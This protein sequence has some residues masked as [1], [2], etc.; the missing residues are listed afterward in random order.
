MLYFRPHCQGVDLANHD[1]VG[2]SSLHRADDRLPLFLDL[3]TPE[4][5]NLPGQLVTWSD[6]PVY[7]PESQAWHKAAGGHYWF[8]WS[9]RPTPESL[10]RERPALGVAWLLGDGQKWMLPRDGSFGHFVDL[11]DSGEPILAPGPAALEFASKAAEAFNACLDFARNQSVFPWPLKRQFE[12]VSEALAVN[13]RVTRE[14]VGGLGLLS[15]DRLIAMI[16]NTTDVD[17]IR[18]AMR[19]ARPAAAVEASI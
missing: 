10:E 1:R 2:L 15:D 12:Y 7:R 13:Y 6:D 11:D 3:E 9:T 4:P 16:S 5:G 17:A 14:V 19:E 8:G 18:Q